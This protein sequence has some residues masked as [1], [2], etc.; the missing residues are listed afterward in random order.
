MDSN[1]ATWLQILNTSGAV[2]VLALIVWR[3]PVVVDKVLL[4]AR[5]LVNAHLEAIRILED[6]CH[7]P[8]RQQG[9]FAPKHDQGDEVQRG[10][11]KE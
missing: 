8:G 3:V 9:R 1:L 11:G 4:F 6:Q 10:Q 7:G 2:A 5:H